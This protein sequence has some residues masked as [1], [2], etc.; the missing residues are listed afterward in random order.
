MK[1]VRLCLRKSILTRQ[2]GLN[3]RQWSFPS[4]SS[5]FRVLTVVF[6]LELF[7]FFGNSVAGGQIKRRNSGLPRM[8]AVA[9]IGSIPLVESSLKTAET[10]YS[11]IKRSNTLFNWYF[12]TAEATLWAAVDSIRPAVR[13]VEG[14]LN[15]ID[16]IMCKSLDI[17]ERRVPIVYLPPQVVSLEFFLDSLPPKF[18][19][20]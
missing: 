9:R 20:F 5:S 10:V 12:S 13:L 6:S 7:F 3:S 14:P 8:E 18:S 19:S 11:S 15:K 2:I 17:V 16:N 1:F 4:S